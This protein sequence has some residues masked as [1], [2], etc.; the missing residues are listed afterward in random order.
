M[1]RAN[2]VTLTCEDVSS[3]VSL[4]CGLRERWWFSLD[5]L[6]ANGPYTLSSSEASWFQ[7][8]Y[9]AS[10]SSEVNW[11]R[12]SRP[13]TWPMPVARTSSEASACSSG[14]KALLRALHVVQPVPSQ[15][16]FTPKITTPEPSGP[17]RNK[18][19]SWDIG[20]IFSPCAMVIMNLDRRGDWQMRERLGG[21]FD[22]HDLRHSVE[23]GVSVHVVSRRPIPPFPHPHVLGHMVNPA[24]A[25]KT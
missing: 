5:N 25:A 8:S 23:H 1:L 9:Q 12:A 7:P 3:V 14:V 19:D 17:P 20:V 21:Q 24:I 10:S 11:D 6:C 13:V 16:A 22:A 4:Y 15:F 18:T 2:I